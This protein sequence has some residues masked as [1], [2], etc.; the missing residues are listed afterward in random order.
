MVV[1]VEKELRSASEDFFLAVNFLLGLDC[2]AKEGC[3]YVMGHGDVD[4]EQGLEPRHS[5]EARALSK[6][7]R[8]L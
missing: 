6:Q 4:L 1:S 5:A 8:G 3:D 7:P 2:R